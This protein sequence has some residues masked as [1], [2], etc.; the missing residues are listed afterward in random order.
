M[1]ER[2][3]I[4]LLGGGLWEKSSGEVERK[5]AAGEEIEGLPVVRARTNR[6]LVP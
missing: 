3:A 2:G 6:A 5:L 1:G 4:G